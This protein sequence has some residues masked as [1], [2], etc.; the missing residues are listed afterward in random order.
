[1]YDGLRTNVPK[2][3]MAFKT[4][5]FED[6]HGSFPPHH[7]VLEYLQQSVIGLEEYV[8]LNVEVKRVYHKPTRLPTS[9]R[10][11]VEVMEKSKTT[12]TLY[13]D[14]VIAANGFVFHQIPPSHP[15]QTVR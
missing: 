11:V 12:R 9:R 4:Q 7:D 8:A 5:A 14:Y 6:H 1:M 15:N 10:W 3:L 2:E 13:C